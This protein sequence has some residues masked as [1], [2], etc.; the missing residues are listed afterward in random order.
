MVKQ[1]KLLKFI[2][3]VTPEMLAKHLPRVWTLSVM[4]AAASIAWTTFVSLSKALVGVNIKSIFNTITVLLLSLGAFG[5]FS[6]SLLPYSS[7]VVDQ[8]H[9]VSTNVLSND[10]RQFLLPY[11]KHAQQY[12]AVNSYGLFRRMTGVGGRPE[13]IVEG[14]YDELGPWSPYEFQYKPGNISRMP[15]FLG[16]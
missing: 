3:E 6:V 10:Y 4:V 14:A 1:C 11:Y 16:K 8:H 12:H 7:I 9:Q 15:P 13:L 2:T 5:L